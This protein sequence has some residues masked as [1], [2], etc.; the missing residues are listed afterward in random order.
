MQSL[1]P[2]F[3]AL[4]DSTR[5]AILARLALGETSVGALSEPFAISAPAISRHLRVLEGAG[6]ISN[7]RVGKQR[8]CRLNRPGL[9]AATAWISELTAATEAQFDRLDTYLKTLQSPASPE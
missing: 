4:A 5:R 6:L 7:T 1:D 3:D 9:A 2:I 8:L